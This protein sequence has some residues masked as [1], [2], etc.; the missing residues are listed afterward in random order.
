MDETNYE[1]T[2]DDLKR[3]AEAIERRRQ[4]RSLIEAGM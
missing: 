4:A 3:L 2:L 1:A